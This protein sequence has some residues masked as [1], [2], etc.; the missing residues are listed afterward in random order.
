MD[1]EGGMDTRVRSD[2]CAAGAGVPGGRGGD[3]G[4]GGAVGHN[5]GGVW[6]TMVVAHGARWWCEA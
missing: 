2:T 4:G 6:G 1:E 3:N 5:G